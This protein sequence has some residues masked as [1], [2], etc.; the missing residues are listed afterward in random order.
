VVIKSGELLMKLRRDPTFALEML[1]QM[2]RRIG[3]L[4]EQLAKLMEEELAS[5]QE[6][7]TILAKS[8]YRLRDSSG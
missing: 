6:L 7:A 2:T 1:Q 8:E 5:R 4:E 3:Y